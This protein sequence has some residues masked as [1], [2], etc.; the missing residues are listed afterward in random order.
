MGVNNDIQFRIVQDNQ[1]PEI[2]VTRDDQVH[3]EEGNQPIGDEAHNEYILYGKIGALMKKAQED[4]P[5][6]G[7][8]R[9]EVEPEMVGDNLVLGIDKDPNSSKAWYKGTVMIRI[10]DAQGNELG[11]AQHMVY[12]PHRVSQDEYD[13]QKA[14]DC[15]RD[16]ILLVCDAHEHAFNTKITGGVDEAT[17]EKIVKLKKQ[18]G[19]GFI[20]AE[21]NMVRG[22]ETI[23]RAVVIHKKDLEGEVT[24]EELGIP[25]KLYER[26]DAQHGKIWR[27]RKEPFDQSSQSDSRYLRAGEYKPRV[28]LK[29]DRDMME[30]TQS[31]NENI[32]QKIADDRSQ[33]PKLLEGIKRENKWRRN[34][35]KTIKDRLL[36]KKG[37]LNENSKSYL[38]HKN[39]SDRLKQK[40]RIFENQI[41]NLNID[42]QKAD[43]RKKPIKQEKERLN[44]LKQ[45]LQVEPLVLTDDQ[46]LYISGPLGLTIPNPLDEV[47]TKQLEKSVNGRLNSVQPNF[48]QVEKMLVD[49]NKKISETKQSLFDVM[50]SYDQDIEMLKNILKDFNSKEDTLNQLLSKKEESYL[51]N[52]DVESIQREIKTIKSDGKMVEELLVKLGLRQEEIILEKQDEEIILKE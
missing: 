9:A 7:E 19:T 36:D 48:D 42:Y 49:I 39:E 14:Q 38:G 50:R 33:L 45:T 40:E 24:K 5:D 41:S 17:K 2:R 29:K 13:D 52:N 23:K 18:L 12:T 26:V 4:N 27:P 21:Y 1:P 35:M 11:K 15:A 10:V 32:Q 8:L 16:S 51:D 31:S 22:G 25:E 34:T 43:L 28:I 30:L 47:F 3:Q 46:K 20:P 6:A 37:E 44:L